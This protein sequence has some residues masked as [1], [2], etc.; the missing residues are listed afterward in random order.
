MLDAMNLFFIMNSFPK[1]DPLS[2]YNKH[3]YFGEI[4]NIALNIYLH[5]A[6]R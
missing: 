4:K 6:Q 5:I 3:F 2:K 1:Q